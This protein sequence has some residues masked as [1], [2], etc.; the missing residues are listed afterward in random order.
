M[1]PRATPVRSRDLIVLWELWL[2][3]RMHMG[4]AGELYRDKMI[5]DDF[6]RNLKGGQGLKQGDF[7]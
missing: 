6:R 4:R 5:Q 3:F 2:R 1:D 7:L